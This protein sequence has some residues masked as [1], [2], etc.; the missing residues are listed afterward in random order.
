MIFFATFHV[1]IVLILATLIKGIIWSTFITVS[2][3]YEDNKRH[4]Q[5][6][7]DRRSNAKIKFTE[8]DMLDHIVHKIDSL[9]LDS[10]V[11]REVY[12]LKM[13]QEVLNKLRKINKN[14]KL[15][16]KSTKDAAHHALYR[17]FDINM[18]ILKEE[19]LM[20]NNGEN[21]QKY[22]M[23][24]IEKFT[25]ERLQDEHCGLLDPQDFEE[26]IQKICKK[27]RCSVENGISM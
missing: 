5:A 12:E 26:R 18:N 10:V 25:R 17:N 22:L 23:Q 3:Q 21:T 13:N 14:K 27:M 4:M 9:K 2:A 8:L 24:V 16:R 7:K 6:E 19:E 11:K 15:A 20:R 1:L